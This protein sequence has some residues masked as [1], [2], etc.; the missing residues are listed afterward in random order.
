MD[1]FVNWLSGTELS[2]TI[3]SVLWLIPATQSVHIIAIGVIFGSIL[4]VDLRVLGVVSSDQPVARVWARFAPWFWGALIVL[5]LTGI[6][7]IIGEP[8]REL[9]AFSFWVKMALIVV[10]V[11]VALAF[12]AHLRANPERWEGVSPA[13]AGTKALAV[14]TIVVWLLV[15]VMG[16]LI[17]FDAQF[18]GSLSPQA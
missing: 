16:R 8:R 18:W 15:I 9:F 11:V 12:R 17:A 3:Q 5:A 14:G 1:S 2:N 6:V 7:L 13:S 10:G 4:M